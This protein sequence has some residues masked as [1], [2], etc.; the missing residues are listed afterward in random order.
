MQP[1]SW[2]RTRMP[3][4]QVEQGWD[5]NRVSSQVWE[6]GEVLQASNT[7]CSWPLRSWEQFNSSES[8]VLVS[9]RQAFGYNA[10]HRSSERGKD[11]R[12]ESWS[13]SWQL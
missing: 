3:E 7:A 12:L 11:T 5:Q 4:F 8:Y 2:V 1:G 10:L 13:L 9:P 6:A